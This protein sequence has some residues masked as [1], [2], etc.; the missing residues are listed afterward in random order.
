MNAKKA[1]I[2]RIVKQE[3]PKIKTQEELLCFLNTIHELL[4]SRYFI[5]LNKPVPKI[6]LKTLTYYKNITKSGSKRYKTFTI[7]KKS[8]KNRVISAPAKGLKL[9][10]QCLNEIFQTFYEPNENAC[11]FIPQRNIT[12]GARQHVKMPYVLNIDLKDFFDT[13]TFPRI[14]KVL[15]LPPF[16]LSGEREQLGYIITSL[17][18]NPKKV[19][20]IDV[21][22]KEIHESR[23][24]LPQGAPT[25]PILT[26]IVCRSL[27]RH[28]AGLARRFHARYTRYADDITFSCHYNIFK[29]DSEFLKEMHRIIENEQGLT[30][31]R[32]KTRLQTPRQRQEVTGLIVNSK[33]NVPKHY[34]KQIRLWLHYWETFGLERAQQ[35]FIGQYVKHREHFLNSHD[36]RIENVLGGKLDYMHMVV[37]DTQAFKKLKARYDVLIT[38]I[39]A[40][41]R[42][43][44]SAKKTKEGE[45]KLVTSSAAATHIATN[46]SIQAVL[47]N[48]PD[49]VAKEELEV[50]LDGLIDDLKMDDAMETFFNI[51]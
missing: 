31:N 30:I 23:N 28:V 35:Y 44:K 36:A 34:V 5:K 37:G 39:E 14:K 45:K 18:C 8:G 1:D 6:E 13:I 2:Q 38:S 41:K 16:N 42:S 50:M 21:E 10:Q 48:A 47:K 19:T 43:E 32:D 49:F 3:F 46:D 26:N 51:K 33:V 9:I 11:G 7:K 27:D 15:S 40:P 12:D 25:S 4:Y 22:G 17:C 24:C 20:T 29:D